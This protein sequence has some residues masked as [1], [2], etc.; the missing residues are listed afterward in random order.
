MAEY[1]RFLLVVKLWTYSYQYV[2]IFLEYVLLSLV[3][4]NALPMARKLA[5]ENKLELKKYQKNR[6]VMPEMFW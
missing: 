6:Y 4:V 3:R 1:L 2:P 5:L